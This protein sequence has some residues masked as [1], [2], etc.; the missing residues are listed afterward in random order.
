MLGSWDVRTSGSWEVGEVGSREGGK[1][2]S[3]GVGNLGSWGV[4]KLRNLNVG[5][6]KVAELVTGEVGAE[7]PPGVVNYYPP[8]WKNAL[9]VKKKDACLRSCG[10][11]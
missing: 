5:S 10:S 1:C 9:F 6:R 8:T 4:G 3:W 2:G 7:T 11:S